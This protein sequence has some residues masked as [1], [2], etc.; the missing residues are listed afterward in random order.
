MKQIKIH[1]LGGQGV[2]TAAKVFAEA[3]ALGELKYAQAIPAYGHERRGAPVYADVIFDDEPI[4]VKSFVYSPDYVVIFDLSVRD[5][6][7]IDI[8]R[9]SGPDTVFIVNSKRADELDFGSHTF[10]CVDALQI[11][12]DVLKR[13]IPNSAMLGAMAAVGLAGI[14]AV[15]DALRKAFGANGDRNAQAARQAF[16]L[17]RKYAC[18]KS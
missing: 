12:L 6:H 16:N 15:S 8:L 7:G 3:V 17:T 13:D 4:K 9:G 1:G 11:A 2:V 14:D 10:Y 5:N 18:V